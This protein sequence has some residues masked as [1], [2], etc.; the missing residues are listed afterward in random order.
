MGRSL[1]AAIA[2][3]HNQKGMIVL[4]HFPIRDP[5]GTAKLGA[6]D[7]EPDQ[8]VGVVN[9]THL[10]RFRIS[11]PYERLVPLVQWIMIVY[12]CGHNLLPPGRV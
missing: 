6:T 3:G 9:D 5:T 11:H 10:I 4:F 2:F 7:L 1:I 12:S 8:V